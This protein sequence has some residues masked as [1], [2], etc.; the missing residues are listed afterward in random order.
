VVFYALAVGVFITHAKSSFKV[1]FKSIPIQPFLMD[2]QGYLE[3]FDSIVKAYSKDDK[4]ALIPDLDADGISSG[5]VAINAIKLL[6]GKEP[7]VITQKH[8]TTEILPQTIQSL[9]DNK[10]TKVLVVDSAV[11]QSSEALEKA[12]GI[13]DEILVVDHHKDYK[14][15]KSEKVFILKAQFVSDIDPSQYPAAKLVYDLFSRHVDLEKFSWIAS[16]GLIGDNQL[17]QWKSFVEQAAEKHG[18]SV[19]EFKKIADIISSVQV[20]APE[21]LN[22][23]IL[24]Y[25]NASSPKELIESEFEKYLET[26]NSEIEKILGEFHVKKEIFDEQELVWFEFKSKNSIKSAVINRVSNE[27]FPNKTVIFVQDL[28]G[29]FVNFSVRRQDFKVKTNELLEKGVEGFEDAGAG[30]HIPAAAGRIK[31]TDLLE[32]KKRIIEALSN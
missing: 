16:V 7:L 17:V 25:A 9:K 15:R 31:K 23:L 6:T 1:I 24:F 5:A 14:Y 12:E 18:S 19:S 29:D 22:E 13:V 27:I 11:E 20:I 10:I 8:K 26:L 30:G 28:G 2:K 3:K 4:I 21:K 32:F